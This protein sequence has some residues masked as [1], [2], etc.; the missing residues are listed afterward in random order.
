[1]QFTWKNIMKSTFFSYQPIECDSCN[2]KYYVNFSTRVF[3]S[4]GL[5]VPMFIYSCKIKSLSTF[6]LYFILIYIIWII[7]FLG[8]IPF[9][10]RYHIDNT[11]VK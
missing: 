7:L 9:F 4:F 3:N 10:A 1:M 6:G 11:T 5:L 8:L 2:T